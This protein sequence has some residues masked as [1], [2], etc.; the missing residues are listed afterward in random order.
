MRLV[1]CKHCRGK[2]CGMCTHLG[3][4]EEKHTPKFRNALRTFLVF[5]FAGM[6]VYTWYIIAS[7]GNFNP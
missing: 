1:R 3:Y 5:W 4:V 6:L 2:G 7:L